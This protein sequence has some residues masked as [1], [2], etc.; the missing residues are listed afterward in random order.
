M[1]D[2]KGEG[3][4]RQIVFQRQQ[5][6]E[7]SDEEGEESL[8]FD[9]A[10][11]F[12]AAKEPIY[13]VQ[14]SFDQDSFD[15]GYKQAQED[16][17]GDKDRVGE[18]DRTNREPE[19]DKNKLKKFVESFPM[20]VEKQRINKSSFSCDSDIRISFPDRDEHDVWAIWA[21]HNC[22]DYTMLLTVVLDKE[23]IDKLVGYYGAA[24]SSKGCSE[25]EAF[26]G[27]VAC[28]FDLKMPRE[29]FGMLFAGKFTPVFY[30]TDWEQTK[31]WA[32][33]FIW[34]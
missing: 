20:W 6:K 27:A 33:S 5:P 2:E 24:L 30:L 28:E 1:V 9:E 17:A 31:G 15:Q 4:W 7:A 23:A 26:S 19:F 12:Q 34:W 25:V 29:G 21:A 13:E 10:W 22:D 16:M 11:R 3:Q 8:I 18:G 14:S 32:D